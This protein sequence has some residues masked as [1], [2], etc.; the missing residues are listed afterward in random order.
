MR[1]ANKNLHK[2]QNALELKNLLAGGA[3]QKPSQSSDF[4]QNPNS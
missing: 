2:I 1:L 4:S 3:A